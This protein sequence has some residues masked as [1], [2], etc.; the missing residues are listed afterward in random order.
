M[1]SGEPLAQAYC[2]ADVFVFPSLTD[3]FGNVLLEALA[4]GVPVAAYPVPGPLD[5]IDDSGAGVLD[6][7]LGK[8]ALEALDIPSQK[9][10][11]HAA[12]FTWDE[13]ARI[14]LEAGNKAA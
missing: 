4:C 3:T 6:N 11:E 1:L 7:D 2:A 14:F 12:K 9:A 13:C 10:L 5:V 8:A